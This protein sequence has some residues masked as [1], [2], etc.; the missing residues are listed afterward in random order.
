MAALDNVHAFK[1]YLHSVAVYTDVRTPEEIMKDCYAPGRDGLIARWDL[2]NV[3]SGQTIADLSGNG[4][5][6]TRP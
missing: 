2:S 3:S 5:N 1:G 4:Y 6:A